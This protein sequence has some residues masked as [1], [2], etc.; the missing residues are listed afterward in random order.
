MN[1]YR[2]VRLDRMSGNRDNTQVL[3]AKYFKDGN[4]SQV[5][6]GTI[7]AIKGLL[8]GERE[9]FEVVD[10]TDDATLVGIVTTPE[11]EY[12][13]NGYHGL[14]TFVNEKDSAIRVH[15]LHPADFFSLGNYDKTEDIKCGAKLVAK[16]KQ[17]EKCG[18]FTME[19]FQVE[20]I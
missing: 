9:L 8:E 20:S 3:S 7:V 17:T 14:E 19:C 11:V 1:K 10:V 2:F 16:H 5:E 15:V 18:R 12:E 6:N 13:E 4:P